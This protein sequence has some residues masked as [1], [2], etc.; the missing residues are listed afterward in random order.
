MRFPGGDAADPLVAPEP[1]VKRQRLAAPLEQASG[2]GDGV[3]AT[4]RDAAEASSPPMPAA[5]VCDAARPPVR[6]SLQ[7]A[8]APRKQAATMVQHKGDPCR[9]VAQQQKNNCKGSG[10]LRRMHS[11]RAALSSAVCAVHWFLTA[12]KKTGSLILK[13][14]CVLPR[15]FIRSSNVATLLYQVKPVFFLSVESATL[16]GCLQGAAFHVGWIVWHLLGRYAAAGFLIVT[17]AL[18]WPLGLFMGICF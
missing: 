16:G 1:A 2:A 12:R 5:P 11:G 9:M 10:C 14:A 3:T 17:V 18:L 7:H 6:K 13:R 15:N 4:N 8:W